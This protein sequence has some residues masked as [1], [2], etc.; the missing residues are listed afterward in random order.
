[1]KPGSVTPHDLHERR[2]IDPRLLLVDVRTPAEF[3]ELRSSYARLMPLDKL[4]VDVI[5][6]AKG[7]GPV[8]CI[9]RSGARALQAA[10][11]LSDAG[12][13]AL[14]VEG[15]TLAWEAVGLPVKRGRKTLSLERQVR[16]GAGLL[17]LAGLVL[18]WLVHPVFLLLCA[19]VGGGLVFAGVTGICGMA[20]VL[21]KMPWNQAS[22]DPAEMLCSARRS[23]NLPASAAASSF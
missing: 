17:V 13:D 21:G 10:Q 2:N 4:D 3:Q 6:S 19:F 18:G 23:V 8:Y 7:E 16:I 20:F 12:V 14:V 1:M 22:V 5:R 11:K 15:G 9:C